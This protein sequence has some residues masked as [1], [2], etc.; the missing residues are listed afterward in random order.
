MN[1]LR[2]CNRYSA[3]GLFF[4]PGLFKQKD[5]KNFKFVLIKI[6]KMSNIR[7]YSCCHTKIKKKE[8]KEKDIEKETERRKSIQ[9][10]GQLNC[11]SS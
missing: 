2:N 3:P 4:C 6:R 9:T 10:P 5:S 8:K 7:K 11:S 1:G